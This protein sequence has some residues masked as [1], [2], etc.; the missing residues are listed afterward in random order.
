MELTAVSFVTF[1]RIQFNFITTNFALYIVIFVMV[2][3]LVHVKSQPLD[4]VKG[5]V[6]KKNSKNSWT[7]RGCV[8]F[9]VNEKIIMLSH[10]ICQQLITERLIIFKINPFY[11]HTHLVVAHYI[12]QSKQNPMGIRRIF[13]WI[14]SKLVLNL[15]IGVNLDDQITMWRPLTFYYRFFFSSIERPKH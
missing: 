2:H 8:C 13:F 14:N 7:N 5:Q 1:D 15:L 9:V 10:K 6:N 3:S 11:F 4:S 12:H